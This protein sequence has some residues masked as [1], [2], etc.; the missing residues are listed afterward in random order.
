MVRRAAEQRSPHNHHGQR[1]CDLRQAEHHTNRLNSDGYLR[2]K[3]LT[4]RAELQNVS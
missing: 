1:W 2:Q 4:G 3:F